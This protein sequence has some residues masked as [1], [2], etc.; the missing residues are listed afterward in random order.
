MVVSVQFLRPLIM[1]SFVTILSSFCVAEQFPGLKVHGNYKN[2]TPLVAK[3]GK[4][5]AD[6]TED[7][8]LKIAKIKLMKGGFNPVRSKTPYHY[9][10]VELLIVGKG[11]KFSLDLSLRK[12][13]QAY[14]HDY[15]IIGDFYKPPQGTYGAIGDA[16][17]SKKYILKAL[18]KAMEKFILDYTDSNT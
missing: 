9:L 12:S 2:L 4:N 15:K 13:A 6:I 10:W 1:F 3:V 14:G 11:T 18:D 17:K 5:K 7:D 16:K 8:L